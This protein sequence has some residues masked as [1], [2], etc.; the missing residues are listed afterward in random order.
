MDTLHHPEP[1]LRAAPRRGPAPLERGP[2]G[3][4]EWL[5]LELEPGTRE[6]AGRMLER[7]ASPEFARLVLSEVQ[8][9][10][11]RGAYAIDAAAAVLTR[12]VAV[13]PS[14]KR[15]RRH[16]APPLF[17]FVGPTG[18]GKTTALVKL[19]RRLREAGRSVVFASLD[20]LSL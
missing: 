10:G 4:D 11:A 20:P 5:G 17:A 7:G 2:L 16:E 15:P 19:G 6:I 1:G 13:L 18:V 12:L 3:P 8:R 9:S 14:P